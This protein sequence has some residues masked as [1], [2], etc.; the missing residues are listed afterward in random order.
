MIELLLEYERNI[1]RIWRS[2][3]PGRGID[4]ASG[5]ECC[6]GDPHRDKFGGRIQPVISDK[7]TIVD[8]MI[9]ARYTED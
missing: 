9:P 6:A 7:K 8:L 5:S 2:S 3:R 4:L 1:Q